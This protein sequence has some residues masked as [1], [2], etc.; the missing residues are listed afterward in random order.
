MKDDIFNK[1]W[2]PIDYFDKMIR[3]A[4]K[5]EEAPTYNTNDAKTLT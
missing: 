1:H 4:Y 5:R 3:D 2:S